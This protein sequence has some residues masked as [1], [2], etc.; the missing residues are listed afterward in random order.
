MSQPKT[1]KRPIAQNERADVHN[2]L[3]QLEVHAPTWIRDIRRYIHRLEDH[4][5]GRD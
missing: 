4:L 3:N 2:M 1:A 5:E